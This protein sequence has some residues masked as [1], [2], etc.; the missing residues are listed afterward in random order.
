LWDNV[1][2]RLEHPDRRQNAPSFFS[3][4]RDRTKRRQINRRPDRQHNQKCGNARHRLILTKHVRVATFLCDEGGT[5]GCRRFLSHL[6]SSKVRPEMETPA[7][8][9]RFLRSLNRRSAAYIM[10]VIRRVS[11]LNCERYSNSIQATADHSQS[12]CKA[13]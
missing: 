12:A 4:D 1:V 10:S 11:R 3:F 9:A 2:A 13:F 8:N 6:A 5:L 7:L